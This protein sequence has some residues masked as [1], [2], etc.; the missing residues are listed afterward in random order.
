[1][2]ENIRCPECDS[3]MVIGISQKGPNAGKFFHICTHYPECSGKILIRG[4]KD[5]DGILV[6]QEEKTEPSTP[7]ADQPKDKVEHKQPSDTKA[8]G[9]RKFAY[10]GGAGVIVIGI[11]IVVIASIVILGDEDTNDQDDTHNQEGTYYQQGYS[12]GHT[13]GRVNAICD[14]Q[15]EKGLISLEEYEDC[16]PDNT[17]G[18]SKPASYNEGHSEGYIDGFASYS[19]N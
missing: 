16:I 19:C 10:L 2:T 13:E 15:Y 11:F 9:K 1:M 14:C 17:S 5:S 8:K 18:M 3:V 7:G 12:A 4:E 6:L